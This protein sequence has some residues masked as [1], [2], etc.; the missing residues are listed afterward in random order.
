[1]PEMQAAPSRPDGANRGRIGTGIEQ[2]IAASIWASVSR[3]VASCRSAASVS[4][5]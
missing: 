4:P 2:Q 1:M 5:A 3:W